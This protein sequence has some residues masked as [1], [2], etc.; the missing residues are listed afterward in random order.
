VS[1]SSM[2]TCARAG[3]TT[4]LWSFD[5]GDSRTTHA[6]D[7]LT[8]FDDEEASKPGAIVLL[9]DGQ[10]WTMDALP[11]ILG[12]LEKAGHELVTIGE[13]LRG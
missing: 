1:L 3:F 9:H 2:L 12:K 10:S 11:A 4:A 7:V 6:D 5:S 13:L 8:A